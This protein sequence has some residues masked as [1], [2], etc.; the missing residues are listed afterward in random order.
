MPTTIVYAV[1]ATKYII[2]SN[3]VIRRNC[4]VLS[5]DNLSIYLQKTTTDVIPLNIDP[6]ANNI[7]N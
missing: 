5:K 1:N 6:I 3:L 2:V 4:S 7:I